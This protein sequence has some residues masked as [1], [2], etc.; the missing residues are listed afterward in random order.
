MTTV[1][2][3]A[4]EHVTRGT[5]QRALVEE[6][7]QTWAVGTEFEAEDISDV[8]VAS[9]KD[10]MFSWIRYQL[11]LYQTDGPCK[12]EWMLVRQASADPLPDM[13]DSSVMEYLFKEKKIFSRGLMAQT[14]DTYGLRALKAELFNVKLYDGEEIRLVVRPISSVTA[15]G[16]QRGIVEY[17]KIGN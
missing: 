17:R 9:G 4:L 13:N 12:Y 8:L 2:N 6:T 11:W 3:V 14:E 16:V 15:T 1:S 10:E 5:Y 7:G